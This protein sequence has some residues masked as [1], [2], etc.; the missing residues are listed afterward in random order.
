MR[1]ALAGI[2]ALVLTNCATIP[3]REEYHPD[4]IHVQIQNETFN[5]ATFYLMGSESGT[6][7]R[8]RMLACNGLSTCNYWISESRSRAILDEGMIHIGWRTD[9]FGRDGNDLPGTWVQNQGSLSVSASRSVVIV[10]MTNVYTY[11]YP[12]QGPKQA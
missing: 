10:Q 1:L 7:A 3:R 2:L 4:Q 6:G 9:Q 5:R 11:L 8:Q 12:G